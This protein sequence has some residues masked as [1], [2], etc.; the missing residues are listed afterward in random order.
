MNREETCLWD[1]FYETEDGYC[2]DC[3]YYYDMRDSEQFDEKYIETMKA[4]FYRD[5][6]VYLEDWN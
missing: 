5:W 2:A 6:I 4:R 1:C 3:P